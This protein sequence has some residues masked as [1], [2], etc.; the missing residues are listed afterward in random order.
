MKTKTKLF[1]GLFAGLIAVTAFVAPAAS[2]AGPDGEDGT[3]GRRG[4]RIVF[5]TA[6]EELGL[7]R[8]ELRAELQEEDD[9]SIA[10]V[11]DEY[12]VSTETIVDAVVDKVEERL[13]EKV[14][15]GDLTQAEADEK[16]AEVEEKVTEKIS[17]P[18]TPGQRGQGR[19]GQGGPGDT[20]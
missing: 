8:Q 19:R 6:A 11:A 14:A 16:L 17:E 4:G 7:T 20:A 13:A 18:F 12:G 10:D 5:S 9:R 3:R 15:D 1:S 2:A